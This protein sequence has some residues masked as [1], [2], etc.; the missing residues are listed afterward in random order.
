MS[1]YI[2]EI[3]K[4]ENIN[5]Q[6][7]VE[8]ARNKLPEHMKSKPW[9]FINHG[10]GL[11]QTEDELN[12]YLAA[13]GE[14]HENKIKKSLEALNNPEQIFNNDIQITRKYYIAAGHFCD[15]F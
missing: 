4:I 9:S 12:C 14:M 8:I 6:K 5:F 15:C 10:I 2:N 7:M 13:Y 3:I 1:N 11:L